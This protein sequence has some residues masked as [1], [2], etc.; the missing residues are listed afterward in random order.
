MR[1]HP[2]TALFFAYISTAAVLKGRQDPSQ[3]DVNGNNGACVAAVQRVADEV[4][5]S[6]C[7]S[8]MTESS[9]FDPVYAFSMYD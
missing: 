3:C 7:Q 2:I 1:L 5:L 8:F 6:D 4:A 9:I